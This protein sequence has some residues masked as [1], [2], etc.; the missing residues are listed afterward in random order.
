MGNLDEM[1]LV[2]IKESLA[3]CDKKQ[4]IA[5]CGEL[6]S[7][8]WEYPQEKLKLIEGLEIKNVQILVEKKPKAKPKPESKPKPKVRKERAKKQ[9]MSD[10]EIAKYIAEEIKDV[11]V[12]GVD[13][14]EDFEPEPEIKEKEEPKQI[15]LDDEGNVDIMLK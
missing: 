12:D 14:P 7:N 5:F 9:E 6:L 8:I 15:K 3:N 13:F 4:L 2:K 1:I 10:E 11:K